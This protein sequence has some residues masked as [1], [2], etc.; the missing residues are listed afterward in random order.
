M[1]TIN[2]LI[3]RFGKQELIDLTD[4]EGA[5]VMNTDTIHCAINDAIALAASF[6]QTVNLAHTVAGV[7][8][9]ASDAAV[10][11]LKLCDMARY[12][13]YEDGATD[14][15][16]KRYALALEWLKQVQKNPSMLQVGKGCAIFVV[17][18]G[19]PSLYE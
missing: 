1:I 11:Q 14:I 3:R 13:L 12:F 9:F 5:G 19:A 8:V 7:T 6:L 17:P 4:T 16:A 2:D 10:L 15:V 18:N